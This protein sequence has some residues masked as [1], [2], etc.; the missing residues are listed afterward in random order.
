MRQSK[1]ISTLKGAETQKVCKPR[2]M[3]IWKRGRRQK[4]IIKRNTQNNAWQEYSRLSCP[5]KRALVN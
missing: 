5:T 4:E 2:Q 1:I 3:V